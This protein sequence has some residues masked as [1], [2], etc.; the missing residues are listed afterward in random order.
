M[1]ASVVAG[2]DAA[3]VFEATEHTFD[4]VASTI[5]ALAVGGWMIAPLAGWDAGFDATRRN[6]SP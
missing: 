1:R 6:C 2:R 5:G 4:E 3:P